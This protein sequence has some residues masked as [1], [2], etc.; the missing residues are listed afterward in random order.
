MSDAA[1]LLVF[2]AVVFAA[3]YGL[4]FLFPLPLL[5][6]ILLTFYFTSFTFIFNKQLV[7]AYSDENKNKFTQIFMG[8]TGI[9]LLSSLVLL[10]C[11]LYLFKENRMYIGICTMAFYFAYTTFEVIL[12]KGKLSAR[13]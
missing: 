10:V 11:F 1:K 9:K 4:S 13:G 3:A 12:W 8:F 7:K 6:L 2:S 5:L